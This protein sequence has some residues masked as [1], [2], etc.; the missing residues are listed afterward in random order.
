MSVYGKLKFLYAILFYSS[1][2]RT[3]IL[4]SLGILRW[5]PFPLAAFGYAAGFKSMASSGAARLARCS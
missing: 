4:E 5:N 3:R 1:E 2:L